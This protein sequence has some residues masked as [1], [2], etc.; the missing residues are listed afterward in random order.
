MTLKWGYKQVEGTWPLQLG[1][2]VLWQA[3]VSCSEN[4]E[5]PR[6][7]GSSAGF[8]LS[9]ANMDKPPQRPEEAWELQPQPCVCMQSAIPASDSRCI[10]RVMLWGQFPA[11]LALL[12][13][14]ASPPGGCTG[15]LSSPA[16]MCAN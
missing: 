11:R 10:S 2:E 1:P 4:Y 5:W 7:V 6:D 13:R 8:A 9:P 14:G 3:T 15:L 16:G 12:Q